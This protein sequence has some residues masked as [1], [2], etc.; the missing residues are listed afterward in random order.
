MID[1]ARIGEAV[2]Y[3]T[4]QNYKLIE[5]PWLVDE[6]AVRL[7]APQGRM[8]YEVRMSPS[9]TPRY[10]PASGEQSFIDMRLRGNLPDGKYVC[11]TPC[12]RDEPVYD[13]L[14]RETFLKVELIEMFSVYQPLYVD[15][16]VAVTSRLAQ[17]FMKSQGIQATANLIFDS[18]EQHASCDLMY[19]GIELGSYGVRSYEGHTWVYGT[20][21][22]E[23]RF[24]QALLRL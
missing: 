12:F 16:Y 21:L 22:A 3:Y 10:L 4:A 23:P 20:G 1:Y 7:T 6:T 15:Y 8:L 5:V 17:D 19:K 11:V 13:E 24:S 18:S 9:L 2:K 14:H